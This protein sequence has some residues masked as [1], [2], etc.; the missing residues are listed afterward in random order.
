MTHGVGAAGAAT[1][2]SG[3]AR[4]RERFI[5]GLED[6]EDEFLD[7]LEIVDDPAQSENAINSI[8][9]K[10]HKLHGLAGTVGFARLGSLAAQ[11]EHHIDLLLAGPRP[12]EV[13]FAKELLNALLD[14][15]ETILK[16]E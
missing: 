14:E 3:I 5:L 1:L 10:A 15:I 2:E 6:R 16:S 11:L 8:R 13:G 9:A 7:Y 12:L 4:I